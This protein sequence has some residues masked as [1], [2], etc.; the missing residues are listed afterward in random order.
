M[1]IIFNRKFPFELQLA[2]ALQSKLA[3]K[4]KSLHKK[5]QYMQKKTNCDKHRNRNVASKNISGV[6]C[7]LGRNDRKRPPNDKMIHGDKL[8]V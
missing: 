5:S 4:E 2:V 3:L 7:H 6:F 8:G 1:H